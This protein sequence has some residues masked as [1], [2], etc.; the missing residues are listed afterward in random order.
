MM[1]LPPQV[2]MECVVNASR[3]YQVNTAV[4]FG[5]LKTEGGRVGRVSGNSNKTYDIGPMQIN[6]IHL[7]DFARY[8]ISEQA[9]LRDGCLN[10][11]AGAWLL[12]REIDRAGGDLW[13]GVGN[14]HSRTPS[15]HRRYQV[16]VWRAMVDM[17]GAPA[18]R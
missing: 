15:L 9:L 14:Y 8:G 17:F 16:R 3:T 11:F 18:S 10:V 7:P 12:R 6:N 2:A 4:L 5:V 1:D 13:R